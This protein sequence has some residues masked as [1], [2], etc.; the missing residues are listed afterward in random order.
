MENSRN[1]EVCNVNVHRASF[2]KHL[3]SK[4]HLENIEQN[5]MIIQDWLFKE[6][7]SPIEKKIQKLYNPKTLKQ[8]AR[9]KVKSDDKDLAEM[10]I[11]PYYFIDE[12][13]KNGFKI[14]LEYHII[15]HANSILTLTPIFPEIGMEFRYINKIMKELSVIYARLIN[16]YSIKYHTLFSASCY[17]INEEDQRKNEIELYVNLNI[18][19]NLTESDIDNIDVRSQLEHQIQNQEMKESGRI[20]DKI[21]LMKLSF[22]KTV[23]LNG[24]SYV[25]IPLR[26]SAI[27]NVQSNDKNCFIWSILAGLHPCV[28]THSTR[29]NNCS[30]YFNELNFHSFDFTNGIK[31]SDVHRFNELNNLSLKIYAIN[32][33][34][35]GD[36]WKHNLIPIDIS[37]NESDNVI[38]LLIYK[39]HYALI[40]KVHV[41]LGNHNKSF[42]CRRCLNSYTCENALINHK[43]ICGNDN[44]CTIRTS[45]ESQ[46]YLKKKHFHKNP[47]YFRIIVDFEADNEIDG[48]NF[49]NQTTNIYKQN[50]VLNGYYIISELEDVLE[51]GYYESP[52]G[53]DDVD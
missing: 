6:E 40:K 33:Y 46:L 45:N 11:N 53:Y 30:Q 48:S 28:N 49:G 13:L 51:S 32:F 10:M 5:E 36:K 7:R 31:C 25:K 27:L 14:N 34:Q 21:N 43:E 4:K 50:P 1:C 8:L 3:R 42:V 17:K 47:L 23:E 16:H 26:S 24:T 22:Y 19:H 41:F 20:F 9:E 18:N 29:K 38:D 35:D 39:N 37:K 12:N 2:V 15:S 44:I 52:L